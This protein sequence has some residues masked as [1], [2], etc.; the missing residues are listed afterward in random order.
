M[1]FEELQKTWQAQATGAKITISTDLLLREVRRNQ[2]NFQFTIVRRDV[3]EVSVCGLMTVF[4][5]A[6]G[7]RWHWWSLY[8]LAFCCLFVGA[9]FVVD[10]L[11]QRRRQ[12]AQNDTLR[13][14]IEKS[15][16]QLNHQIWLL[17]NVFWWYLLPI[18]IGLSA[19]TVSTVWSAHQA[20]PG[21]MIGLSAFYVIFYG[22]VYGLVYW[23]NQWTV[24]KRLEP[25]RHELENLLASLETAGETKP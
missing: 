20:G 18:L 11:I 2:R 8:L 14:C 22:L 1:N 19:V 9:F 3:V 25:R 15:L 13:A 12:P 6:W 5:G 16:H 24:R 10:R 17:K 23:A 4:F 21:T 7:L